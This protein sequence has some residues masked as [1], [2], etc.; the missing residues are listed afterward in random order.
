MIESSVSLLACR[1]ALEREMTSE[2]GAESRPH[3]E[4]RL[5]LDRDAARQRRHA[6]GAAR[7]L[8]GLV[9]KH[10]D[11]QIAEAVDDL[12]M[13]REVRRGVYHAE[14]FHHAHHLV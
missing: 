3:L 12:R 13:L 4:N 14:R 1:F 7:P 2:K 10:L 6:D 8:A 9:A 11:H 5:D